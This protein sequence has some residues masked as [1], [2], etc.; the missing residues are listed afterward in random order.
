[1]SGTTACCPSLPARFSSNAVL[2]ATLVL[3][4]AAAPA[5][6]ARA[7]PSL[8]E[9]YDLSATLVAPRDAA[10]LQDILDQHNA[11]RLLSGDYTPNCTTTHVRNQP[12]ITDCSFPRANLTVRSGQ[13]IWG[14]PG[15]MLPDIIVEAGSENVTLS[16]LS[17]SEGMLYFAPGGKA[18]RYSTFHRIK[19]AHVLF[20]AGATVSDCSFVGLTEVSCRGCGDRLTEHSLPMNIGGIHAEAGSSVTNC[21]FI[22]SMVHAPWAL[23]TVRT[24]Q[25]VGN[26]FLWTN[27]LG[28]LQASFS[29]TDAAELTIVGPDMETYGACWVN[30]A[31]QAENVGSLRLYG[32]HG[33]L[34][35]HPQNSSWPA[36]TPVMS[37]DAQK[38]WIS[39][40]TSLP[41]SRPNTSNPDIVLGNSVNDYLRVDRGSDAPWKTQSDPKANPA[42]RLKLSSNNTVELGDSPSKNGPLSPATQASLAAMVAS[43]TGGGR[44]TWSIASKPSAL[45]PLPKISGS[46]DDTVKLQAMIDSWVIS[47]NEPQVVPAGVYYISKTL[48]VGRLPDIR[49]NTSACLAV[50]QVRMLVG[51]GRDATVILARDPSMTMV[52]I[53]GCYPKGNTTGANKWRSESSRF[54]VSGVTLAG[55]A[56]GFHFSAATGHHQIVD[57]MISHV[58]F[59]DFSKYGIWLDDIFGLD[60][61][62]LSF[63]SFDKCQV[64]FYQ[65]APDSQRVSPGGGFCKPAR[66]NPFLGYMDKNVF[67]RVQVS[68]CLTGFQLD[69]CRADNLNYWVENA[70]VDVSGSGWDLHSNSEAAIVS[71]YVE[72]VGLFNGGSN[73]RE[74]GGS[75]VD[76]INS[77]MI[78][79][80][81]TQY[82]LPRTAKIEGSS[83]EVSSDVNPNA[84]LF[85]PQLSPSSWPSFSMS[86]SWVGKGLPLP[87]LLSDTILFNN[88][89]E[90]TVDA[91]LNKVAV[92]VNGSA[93]TALSNAQSEE[94]PSSGLCFGPAW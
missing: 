54:H 36:P 42:L 56:V 57:S 58:R 80:P 65:R 60:N 3:L 14:L 83:F 37:L 72:N 15:A 91:D 59:R 16:E 35:C 82:L 93:I 51:S 5:A 28:S 64:A 18:T 22:R 92:A 78:A 32:P 81:Q 70:V 89:F 66:I 77:H 87:K 41:V 39:T 79:G 31:I 50:K 53:D 29:A 17:F 38:I 33:R 94:K 11:V 8:R 26:T 75:G 24:K 67:Y 68:N 49:G 74:P 85:K 61:N 55:G 2:S 45:P 62:L 13:Q 23:L 4:H 47:P 34:D 71:S 10:N 43:P 63:L 90:E 20:G 44:G 52:T 86:R 12:P 25:W 88:R 27:V 1:M 76:V 9:A 73:V 84:T 46:R 21:K 19:G 7:P 6:T 48:R 40:P 69:A 30:P